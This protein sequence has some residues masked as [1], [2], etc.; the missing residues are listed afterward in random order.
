M[1]RLDCYYR[2]FKDYRRATADRTGCMKDRKRIAD[3]NR[4]Q[5][6]LE[7]IKYLCKIKEDWVAAI[8]EGLVYVEKAVAEERQFIRTNGE[9]VPIEKVKKIS[10]D[11]VEHLERHSDMITHVPENEDDLLVPDELYMVEKLSDYAVY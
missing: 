3:S 6:K 5:D 10:K 8:E 2:G 9:V 1:R 4:E 11:S 7:S